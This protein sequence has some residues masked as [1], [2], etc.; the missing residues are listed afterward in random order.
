MFFW[1]RYI[2]KII[3]D[4]TLA[5][6][7]EEG[8]DDYNLLYDLEDNPYSKKS[9]SAIAWEVGWKL[10]EKETFIFIMKSV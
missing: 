8:R 3:N 4:K 10:E 9:M 7:M 2:N 1:K 5:A 6:I